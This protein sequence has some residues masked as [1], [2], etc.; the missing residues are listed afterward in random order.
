[1]SAHIDGSY[2]VWSSSDSTNPKEAALTP[3]G[4]VLPTKSSLW[5]HAQIRQQWKNMCL[6]LPDR[7][8][9]I[10]TLYFTPNTKIFY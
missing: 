7:L 9:T 10:L 4:N 6:L 5:K 2:T 1:M 8:Y 3:Y